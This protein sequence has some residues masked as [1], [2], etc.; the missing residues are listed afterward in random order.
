MNNNKVA[1]I[2]ALIKAHNAFIQSMEDSGY[3]IF[4]DANNRTGKI[5]KLL[6]AVGDWPVGKVT[7]R[8]EVTE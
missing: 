6:Y 1:L 8:W 3:C 4:W 2:N 5:Y 7:I